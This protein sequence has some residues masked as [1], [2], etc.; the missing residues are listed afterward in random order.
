MRLAA[1]ADILGSMSSPEAG[2]REI[3][4]LSVDGLLVAGGM[5]CDSNSAEALQCLQTEHA[6][7]MPR[8]NEGYL[9]AAAES[10]DWERAVV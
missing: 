2:F 5:P 9:D 4:M 10:F 3:H 6:W 1:I 8:N 7:M